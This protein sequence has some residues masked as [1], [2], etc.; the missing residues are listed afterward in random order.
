MGQVIK[1]KMNGQ[2]LVICSAGSRL[3]LL[4]IDY[5]KKQNQ[6]LQFKGHSCT[7][8]LRR[9]WWKTLSCFLCNEERENLAG[10]FV[11]CHHKEEALIS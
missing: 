10:V 3:L 6:W 4:A 1:K 7:Q 11:L 5:L 9:T 2:Q 8:N